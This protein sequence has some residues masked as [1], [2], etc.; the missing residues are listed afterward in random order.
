MK[1]KKR[2]LVAPLNWGLGH[3]TRCIPIINALLEYSFEPIIASDGAALELLKKEFSSLKHIELPS[4]KISYSDK[5]ENLKLKLLKDVPKV[6][7][8]IKT[9]KKQVKELVKSIKIDGIISDNRFG[10]YNKK[11]PSVFITHQLNVLSG[12]TTWLSS[13]INQQLIAK[14][15]ECWVPDVEGLPNLSGKLGH[16][17]NSSLKVKYIGS[18]SR[19][20]KL[21]ITNKYNLMVL[22]SGP[23]PQRTLLEEHLLIELSKYKGSVLFVKGLVEPIQSKT[24]NDNITLVNFMQSIELEQAIAESELILSRSGYT[25][26]LDLSKMEKKAFFIPTPGQFEQEYL[27]QRLDDKKISPFCAQDKFTLDELKRVSFYSGFKSIKSETNF[28]KL[29]SL[30]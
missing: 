27:A 4:Y 28:E 26:L 19:F 20:N 14:F 15:D 11:I 24:K 3:A 17:Q 13:T 10:V 1:L 30:F 8:A 18:I 9:E 29:F 22:L 5:G 7:K 21:N 23:E 12:N 25:T 2:I 6:L 16:V